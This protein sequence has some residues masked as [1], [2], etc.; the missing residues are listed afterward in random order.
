M[1]NANLTFMK[2]QILLLVVMLFAVIG[3]FA[4]TT[5]KPKGLYRLDRFVYQDGR[6]KS[7]GFRQY[8]YAADS[9]GLLIFYRPSGI[10][11]QWDNLSVEIRENYPLLNTGEKPQGSDGHGT[12][13]F[14]VDDNQ[15]YFK[16]YNDRWSNM[17]N[18]GE[19]ITEIY[20]KEGIED[21]VVKAF[22]LFENKTEGQ[23]S[24]FYGWWKRTGAA[25]HPDGSGQH[26]LLP[27]RW[28]AYGPGLSMVLD[29]AESGKAMGCYTTSTISYDNDSSIHEIGHVCNIYWKDDDTHLLTF[30]QENGQPLTEIWVRSGLPKAWQTVFGTDIPT[31]RGGD[32]CLR[33]ALEAAQKDDLQR[34]E[35]LIAEA[36]DEKDANFASLCASASGIV[37]MLYDKQQYKECRDIGEKLL[38]RIKT[39]LESGHE[40]IAVSRLYTYFTEAITAMAT[41]RSGDQDTGKRKLEGCV[42]AIDSEIEKYRTVRSM[43]GYV[44][45]L[46]ACNLSTYINGYDIFGSERTLL[47]LDAISLMAPGGAENKKVQI[48]ETRA[49]CY[50]LS[51]NREMAQKLWQQLKDSD[52]GYV[53]NLPGDHPLKSVFGE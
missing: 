33:E 37:G 41:Y 45:A 7:P 9:V 11:T 47:Y 38:Q 29:I 51:G 25:E 14:N 1:F 20:K 49:K 19:F 23:K 22:R 39:Y 18:L 5:Q 36:V 24:R 32:E 35:Q 30:V 27:P 15:F 12:Q 31:Y 34:A 3:G 13:I 10:K 26:R 50:L 48:L 16:W 28:K 53:K 21:D 44:G 40:Y 17:S 8:K 52:A 46:Y 6:T 43:D 2:K 4:Q 42:S